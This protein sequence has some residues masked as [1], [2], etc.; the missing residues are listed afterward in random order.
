MYIVI[1]L[2]LTDVAL[3]PTLFFNIVNILIVGLC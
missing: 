3:L 1:Y 2:S